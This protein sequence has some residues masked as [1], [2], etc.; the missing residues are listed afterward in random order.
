MSVVGGLADKCSGLETAMLQ[1]ISTLEKEIITE[2][3]IG[4]ESKLTA[5]QLANKLWSKIYSSKIQNY[6]SY[7]LR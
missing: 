1:E 2:K 7:E 6:R 5:P 4:L 3:V